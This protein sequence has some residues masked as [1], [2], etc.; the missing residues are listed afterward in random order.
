MKKYTSFIIPIIFGVFSSGVLAQQNS[1]FEFRIPLKGLVVNFPDGASANPDIPEAPP[2]PV[3]DGVSRAGACA[4][5][6]ATGCATWGV[7]GISFNGVEEVYW[8]PGVATFAITYKPRQTGKWYF[9]L[10]REVYGEGSIAQA[11]EVLGLAQGGLGWP[12]EE[13]VYRNSP[14]LSSLAHTA[15]EW[16]TENGLM[17]VGAFNVGGSPP[18]TFAPIGQNR[19]TIG[20]AAD[21]DSGVVT[22][23]GPTGTQTFSAANSQLQPGALYT[24]HVGGN[25]SASGGVVLN[26]GQRE[27]VYPVPEGFN[28]GWW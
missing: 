20:I 10:T 22:F 14:K 16:R 9:E 6:A 26:A 18:A 13:S 15:V 12:S 28:A 27:F 23:Q 11:R 5:G 17:T 3:G 21:L 2:S 19:V 8:H 25:W 7:R 1:L 4:S 24:P